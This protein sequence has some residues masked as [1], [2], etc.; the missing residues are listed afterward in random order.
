MFCLVFLEPG[1]KG[2]R[3]LDLQHGVQIKS[4]P[5]AK[6]VVQEVQLPSNRAAEEKAK[7]WKRIWVSKEHCEFRR[8]RI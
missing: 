4:V 1:K 3:K 2:K 6:Q 7:N 8:T 5:A